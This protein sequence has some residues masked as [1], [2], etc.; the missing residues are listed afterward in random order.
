MPLRGFE[1]TKEGLEGCRRTT[2]RASNPKA[3]GGAARMESPRRKSR[4]EKRCPK[5]NEGPEVPEEAAGAQ[6]VFLWKSSS[7]SHGSL[8]NTKPGV[9]EEGPGAPKI[10]K[11]D[12]RAA[13]RR[14]S[15]LFGNR[16]G[17]YTGASILMSG[18][19]GNRSPGTR[20]PVRKGPRPARGPQKRWSQIVPACFYDFRTPFWSSRGGPGI[21]PGALGVRLGD[22]ESFPSE[23]KTVREEA[24]P[25]KTV[26]LEIE[27]APAREHR[28]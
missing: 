17:A 14:R 10:V 16:A 18:G 20:K 6:A 12:P 4:S 25:G 22:F 11:N 15:C 23:E 9:P 26:F 1:E 13:A 8:E 2:A 21:L 19:S 24:R 5:E 3:R 7:L 27:L 28:F